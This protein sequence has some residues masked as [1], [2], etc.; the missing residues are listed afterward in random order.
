MT[1]VRRLALRVSALVVRFAS[2]S[3]KEWA[4]GSLQ[5]TEH[6]E[7][8]WAA[9]EWALGSTRVLLDRRGT[10]KQR[11][12][13]FGSLAEAM[14]AAHQFVALKKIEL[15]LT[16]DRSYAIIALSVGV[17]TGFGVF[18]A[19]NWLQR[20]G[21]IGVALAGAVYGVHTLLE[22]KR[23]R[24][25][26]DAD[27]VD[28]LQFYRSELQRSLELSPL[29]LLRPYCY[30]LWTIGVLLSPPGLQAHLHGHPWWWLFLLFTVRVSL[31][32]RLYDRR[33][34]QSTIERLNTLLTQG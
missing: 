32:S 30:V 10:P 7:S 25:I 28:E 8:D 18:S 13:T 6:I 1:L 16:L 26:Q 2:A 12:A 21:C 34:R 14:E 29:E 5:E 31:R 19:A 20:I 24:S 4:K 23:L 15:G 9:L 3:C 33:A 17:G 22:R 27:I 11:I